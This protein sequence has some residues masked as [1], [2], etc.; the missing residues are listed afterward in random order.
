MAQWLEGPN[1]ESRCKLI[2]GHQMRISGSWGSIQIVTYMCGPTWP[3]HVFY[4]RT[5]GHTKEETCEMRTH[6]VICTL[7]F[8]SFSSSLFS[9]DLSK[10]IL[11]ALPLFPLIHIHRPTSAGGTR[12]P[13]GHGRR[14][15][16]N[17]P[18]RRYTTTKYEKPNMTYTLNIF[19]YP[20]LNFSSQLQLKSR[21][22]KTQ[23]KLITT[24]D[25][26]A[27]KNIDNG[28]R[29]HIKSTTQRYYQNTN[30]NSHMQNPRSTQA[31]NPQ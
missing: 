2:C 8:F 6:F 14:R 13:E 24:I 16:R 11:K 19:L 7:S 4:L 10:H 29:N 9:S 12:R 1:S 22:I 3:P 5:Q 31:F 21:E 25:S 28:T 20:K 17:H 30:R 27:T 18:L 23:H 15:R 26:N